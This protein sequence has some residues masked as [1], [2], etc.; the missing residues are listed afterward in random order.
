M[1]K[2]PKRGPEWYIQRDLIEYLQTRSWL[3]ERMIGNA[4]Q[5]GIPDLFA[6]HIKWGSRWIDVKVK[7]RYTFTPA[8]KIKWPMWEKHGLGIWILVAANQSEYNKLFGPPNFRDYWKA[9]WDERPDIDA[10]LDE[11]NLDN[12][13]L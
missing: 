7:N 9:S 4:Y 12:E 2:R 11:L 8:Q 5:V 10:M 3:V 1:A 6:H 13:Q